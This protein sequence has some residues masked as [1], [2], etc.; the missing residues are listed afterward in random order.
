MEVWHLLPVWIVRSFRTVMSKISTFNPRWCA[1]EMLQRLKVLNASIDIV[2]RMG[3]VADNFA[4]MAIATDMDACCSSAPSL[5]H[6]DLGK[7]LDASHVTSREIFAQRVR[8][9]DI[10]VRNSHRLRR[11]R[12]TDRHIVAVLIAL[13]GRHEPQALS[14]GAQSDG[15][16]CG[17]LLYN[18]PRAHELPENATS[19]AT[20]A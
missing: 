13:F 10:V 6:L 14:G 19:R 9:S 20:A 5:G 18:A 8:G 11:S 1:R 12:S 16:A 15:K 2:G 4:S 17:P 7:R 3:S